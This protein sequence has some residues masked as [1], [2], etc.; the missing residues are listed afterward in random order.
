METPYNTWA[1]E[2]AT[3]LNKAGYTVIAYESNS[4]PILKDGEENSKYRTVLD[5]KLLP[6]QG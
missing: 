4:I 2:L 6:P 1:L 5:L 3:M